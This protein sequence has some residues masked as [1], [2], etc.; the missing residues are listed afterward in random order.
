LGNQEKKGI[1]DHKGLAQ[2]WNL[3]EKQILEG[4]VLR[5]GGM[6]SS[7]GDRKKIE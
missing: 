7:A 5:K 3:N 4:G 6:H 2:E 1:S